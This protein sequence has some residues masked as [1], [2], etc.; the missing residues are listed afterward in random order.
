MAQ[1]QLIENYIFIAYFL[2]IRKYSMITFY[3]GQ[4]GASESV[5]STDVDHER[6]TS[7]S[8][9]PSDGESKV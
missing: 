8:Q 4:R 6:S 1:F 3:Y 2:K 7:L 5:S 9:R